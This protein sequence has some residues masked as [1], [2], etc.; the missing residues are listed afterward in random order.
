MRQQ[1][2]RQARKNR[3]CGLTERLVRVVVAAYV[4]SGQDL[5]LAR[6][7]GRMLQEQL[8]V[9]GL[10][11]PGSHHVPVQVWHAATSPAVVQTF[12]EPGSAA[13]A[14]IREEALK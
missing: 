4:L 12:A 8:Q 6:A 11:K 3:M 2:I 1:A 9:P 10:G 7:V 14:S 5:E 13:E